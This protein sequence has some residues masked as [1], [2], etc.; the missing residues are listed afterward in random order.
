MSD[1]P[2][3]IESIPSPNAAPFMCIHCGSR[4]FDAEHIVAIEG[5]VVWMCQVCHQQTFGFFLDDGSVIFNKLQ[6][7]PDVKDY[8]R[9]GVKVWHKA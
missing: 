3:R 9:M 2:K 5:L 7:I 8:A 4:V 6:V 1:Q